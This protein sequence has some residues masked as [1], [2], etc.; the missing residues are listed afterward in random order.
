MFDPARIRQV[1]LAGF[2]F[3]CFGGIQYANSPYPID[4]PELPATGVDTVQ[5]GPFNQSQE[6]GE[7]TCVGNNKA[8]YHFAVV[9]RALRKQGKNIQSCRFGCFF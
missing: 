1:F 4:M 3:T 5:P 8:N 2:S 7:S 6:A 9:A